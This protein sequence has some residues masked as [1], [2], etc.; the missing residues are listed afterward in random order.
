MSDTPSPT[1][2]TNGAH[3]P[4]AQALALAIRARELGNRPKPSLEAMKDEIVDY[5]SSHPEIGLTIAKVQRIFRMAEHGWPEQQC[6]L[7]EGV[8]ERD[9]HLRCQIEMRISAV[10]GKQWIM[11]PGGDAPAD[12]EAAAL[13]DERLRRVPNVHE[14]FGHLLSVNPYGYAGTEILWEDVDGLFSPIWFENVPHRRIVFDANDEPRL[15]VRVGEPEGVPLAPGSWLYVA[16]RHRRDAMAG[17]MRTAVFYSLFKSKALTS[18]VLFNDRF[19]LPVPIGTY[20][21]ATPAEEKAALLAALDKLGEDFIAAFHES[22]KITSLAM[23][24]GGNPSTAQGSMIDLC[25][26]EVSKLFTGATLTSGEGTSAGSYAQATVHENRFYGFTAEDA[27]VRLPQIIHQQLAVPF[28]QWNGLKGKPPRIKFH[29]VRE[30]DPAS[31]MAIFEG[32]VRL[33]MALDEDQ[34]RTEMQLKSVT[35]ASIGG[36]APEPQVGPGAPTEPPPEGQEPPPRPAPMANR[37]AFDPN[38]PR[39]ADGKWDAGGGSAKGVEG[40]RSRAA[41][42]D[43]AGEIERAEKAIADGD[44]EA[45][46]AALAAHDRL[47]DATGEHH[48]KLVEAHGRLRDAQRDAVE[49]VRTLDESLLARAGDDGAD[50]FES[51]LSSDDLDAAAVADREFFD[52]HEKLQ[53]VLTGDRREPREQDL[54]S[55]GGRDGVEFEAAHAEALASVQKLE[56]EHKAAI[57]AAKG[58]EAGIGKAQSAVE[59]EAGK[60]IDAAED[61]NPK[62]IKVK[63][64]DED[65]D[66][67]FTEQE[68]D[69]FLEARGAARSLG[70]RIS[71]DAE[72]HFGFGSEDAVSALREGARSARSLLKRIEKAGQPKAARKRRAS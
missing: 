65:G 6:D 39:A 37:L 16:G 21:D 31:R 48:A 47:V 51:L 60:Y 15:R 28:V 66:E 2:G 38:Q 24:G 25:N 41:G 17:L 67:P 46:H 52:A 36:P 3:A 54:D 33:G 59:R 56:A 9:A 40:I 72:E 27:E 50:T 57:E 4:T 22:C 58:A 34:V 35:G 42:S 29:L 19:G 23:E 30:T 26:A 8:I 63:H 62:V 43:G 71:V 32:A 64:V 1:N 45:P 69:R 20:N 11:L 14:M 13:L 44:I 70:E 18:W 61:A 53:E 49:K 7:F 12:L 68:L 5:L 55:I 10:A